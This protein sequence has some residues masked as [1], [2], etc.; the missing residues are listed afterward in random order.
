MKKSFQFKQDE[1]SMISKRILLI[2]LSFIAFVNVWAQNQSVSGVI[3]DSQNEAL[4]GVIIKVV[5]T[6]NGTATDIDGHYSIE[7]KIGDIL[8]ITCIGMKSQNVTI[9][10]SK[11]DI[12]MQEDNKL[13]DEV[14]VIGYGSAKAKDLT[15]NITVIKGDEMAKHLT[16]SPMQAMQGKVAGV[17]I[18]GS[19]Q[20]GSSPTVRIR[21]A[22]NM[23]KDKQGPLYVV[24][25]MFFDNI[26]FLSNNDIE[27]MNVLKDASS[28][29]IY[30]VRAAN[31]VVLI[32]T[33]K[34][35]PNQKPRITYDGYVGFQKATNVMKMANSTQY[36]EIFKE[37][38]AKV[39][40][41]VDESIA[42]WGGV[43]G[44]PSINT[45]WYKELLTTAPMHSHSVDVVGGSKDISYAVGVNYLNQKGIMDVEN[46]YER[47]NTRA[48]ID[49]NVT[50]WLKGGVNFVLSNDEK[51][52]NGGG[53]WTHA[54]Y[55]PSIYPVYDAAQITD[56][57][58]LGFA[59]G[60]QIGLDQLFANPVAIAHYEK[61]KSEKR[62]RILP[63]YYLQANLLGDKLS[64]K[65]A[66]SQDIEMERRRDVIPEFWIAD[67]QKR[68]DSYLFK[69]NKFTNNWILDNTITF[70][71]AKNKHNYSAML[72]HSIRQEHNE[73]LRVEAKGVPT[74]SEEYW[75]IH[76]GEQILQDLKD[77]DKWADNGET[78]RG[79]SY[80]GRLTYD[81]DG[82]YLLSATFRADGSSKYQEKWGYFPSVGLGWIASEETAIKNLEI[83]DFLKLRANW[84]RL[85]NDKIPGSTG[86]ASLDKNQA[87]WNDNIE[88]GVTQTS[89][90]SFLKWEIV[91][92][93]NL[94]ID[95]IL[96]NNRL[97]FNLDYFDRT[98]K[99]AVFNKK[100]SL[101][102]QSVLTNGGEINNKGVEVSLDWNDKIG[103][104]FSYNIGLNA[105]YLKN[106]VT[107]L[108]G[109]NQEVLDN[110]VQIHKLGYAISSFYGYK[111]EGVYQNWDEIKA[112]PIALANG[113][114]LGDFKYKDVDGDNKL[115]AKDRT[116]LGSHIPKFRLGGNLGFIYKNIDFNM[117]FNGVFNYQL[118]N[119]KR[120]LRSYQSAINFDADW[121]ENRWT[122]EGS[123]N[124]YPSAKGS[125]K[126]WNQ[127]ANSFFV[128]DANTFNIQNITLGYTFNNILPKSDSRS[129][130]RVSL[131]AERPFSTF[132]YN[133]FSTDVH[134]GID[135]DVY[136][137]ASTYSIGFKFIY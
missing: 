26:D 112:D 36:A 121:A 63:S 90:F 30:G 133:G 113:L 65:T 44:I 129:S 104:D 67:N 13:L 109:R 110:S 81:Y 28:S 101:L 19:G 100:V 40:A 24:D 8:E 68:E 35:L 91:E 116:I 87:I 49:F 79:V 73:L 55:S 21:G 137:M 95:L 20:P 32:T 108:D 102:P 131:T 23:D 134:D 132:S 54:Y 130:L 52:E 48:R 89:I 56:R 50:N 97:G 92:E 111:V 120:Y 6:N 88:P 39:S 94:G 77:K 128:E 125:V 84:G 51:Q 31:G 11:H 14:V 47:V 69:R 27:S 114:E 46:G 22:G 119:R 103:K 123:T 64:L 78:W 118:F 85:G 106:K 93:Y 126:T 2:C 33:K 16:S 5:G 74:D 127:N 80:F 38:D 115:T 83:F 29:A 10:S 105:T 45:D 9:T 136:P 70:R 43:N 66:L 53:A 37:A 42:K 86:F 59:S 107:K 41:M 4:I 60:R 58:P 57:N 18:V 3:K 12:V 135:A 76:N 62:M 61:E 17:Q 75:Y 124:S 117:A 25:G 99:N 15:S 96:L 72:G 98:T 122:G 1:R 34:G 7:A 71:D 82:K